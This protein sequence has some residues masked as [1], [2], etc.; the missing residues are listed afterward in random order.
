MFA[1]LTAWFQSIARRHRWYWWA[2][3]TLVFNGFAQI[4]P[5]LR[6]L[7]P[8]P[9]DFPVWHATIWQRLTASLA[10]LV[11]AHI[12]AWHEE[13]SKNILLTTTSPKL[14]LADNPVD[15]A[16]FI[17]V[18]VNSGMPLGKYMAF[19]LRFRNKPE[20][21][22][23]SANA[24]GINARITFQRPEDKS[25]AFSMDARW[26]DSP[27]PSQRNV[28]TDYVASLAV[29]FPIG[30]ERSVDILARRLTDNAV[31]SVN[32]DNLHPGSMPER[33]LSGIVVI[34]VELNGSRV[35]CLATVTFDCTEFQ[36][37][38]SVSVVNQMP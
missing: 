14:V 6:T 8:V 12:V 25:P 30:A 5:W 29:P 16:P 11:V 36:P 31:F 38:S 7:P 24:T 2:L 33:R 21:N 28:A 26:A 23:D 22:A 3:P 10:G 18:D 35:K 15:I 37:L 27:Q 19:R 17:S 20:V 32:N 9:R 13:Y 4:Y 34:R 1:V